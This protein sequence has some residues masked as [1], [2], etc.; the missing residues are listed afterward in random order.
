MPEIKPKL[1][2]HVKKKLAFIAEASAEGGGST[3]PSPPLKNQVF[4]LNIK[5]LIFIGFLFIGFK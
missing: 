3:Y 2:E 4:F 1:R 5:K